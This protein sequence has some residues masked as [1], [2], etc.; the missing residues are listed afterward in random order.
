M[1]AK[2]QGEGTWDTGCKICS[3]FLES[4]NVTQPMLVEYVKILRDQMQ[5]D[6][7][8]LQSGIKRAY[9]VRE[10]DGDPPEKRCKQEVGE[11]VKEEKVDKSDDE[12]DDTDAACM[13]KHDLLRTSS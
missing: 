1:A 9:G 12:K 4:M 2:T 11:E 6:H 13:G 8:K 5:K 7:E 10:V 3:Q